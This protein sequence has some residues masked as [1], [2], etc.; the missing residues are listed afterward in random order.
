MA[1]ICFIQNIIFISTLQDYTLHETWFGT[2]L[3]VCNLRHLAIQHMLVFL[4]IFAIN[5]K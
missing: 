3:D 1:I 4:L 2:K 5:W